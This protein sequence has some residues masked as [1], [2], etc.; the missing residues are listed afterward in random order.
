M[1]LPSEHPTRLYRAV[2][3]IAILLYASAMPFPAFKCAL[4][5]RGFEGYGV[6]MV[7]WMGLITLDPRWLANIG[8]FVLVYRCFRTPS[9]FPLI[10]GASILLAIASLAPAAGCTGGG[11][12]PTLSIGLS[13]SGWLWVASISCAALAN[14][15]LAP[16]DPIAQGEIPH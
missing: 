16:P 8:F 2:T 1:S 3:L 10:S 4:G 5:S 7:G 11:G 14:I 13:F 9:R 15:V 12:A 6:L